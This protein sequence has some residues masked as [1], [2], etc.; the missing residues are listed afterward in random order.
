[1]DKKAMKKAFKE[2]EQR[3]FRESLP[4]KDTDFPP[5]FDFLDNELDQTECANDLSLLKKYCVKEN[6]DFDSLKEWFK[7]HGGYCDCEILANVEELFYYLE[8]PAIPI[9]QS[10][11]TQ[12]EQRTKLDTLTTD[13]G[14]S[15]G[16]VPSP[17]ILTAISKDNTLFYQFKIGKKSDYPVLLEREFPIEKLADDK[18]LHDYWKH[19]MKIAYEIE[20]ETDELDFEIERKPFLDFEVVRVQTKKWKSTFLFVHKQGFKWCLVMKTEAVRAR[21]DIKELEKLLKEI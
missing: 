17:W 14:F 6:L 18:F 15:I 4:M 7:K 21:N 9:I 10:K 19:Q 5:L 11:K 16:K 13:F 20:F 8:K 2:K 12:T 1:M 3:A